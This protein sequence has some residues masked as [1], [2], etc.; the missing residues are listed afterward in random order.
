MY[1]ALMSVGYIFAGVTDVAAANG[2]LRRQAGV[3]STG[4]VTSG[5][6]FLFAPG[7][8]LAEEDEFFNIQV[9]DNAASRL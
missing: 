9:E 4:V 5:G 3:Q 6:T 2:A 8:M 1:M 7:L